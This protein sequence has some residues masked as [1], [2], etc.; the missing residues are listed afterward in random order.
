M[1]ESWNRWRSC[2]GNVARR[3]DSRPED[4]AQLVGCYPADKYRV[5]SEQIATAV[6]EVCAASVVAVRAVFQQFAFAWLTGNGDLHAKNISVL[7]QPNGE[8]RVAPMYDLRSTLPYGDVTMALPLAGAEENLSRQRFLS[9]AAEVGLPRVAA[10]RAL[11]EVL[12]VTT[13]LLDD[14]AKGVLPFDAHRLHTMARQ[15]RNRRVLLEG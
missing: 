3:F 9:F 15:L 8:W 6:S 4:A 5:S 11:D 2:R 14:L 7:Q 10:E 12:A 13:P 1:E